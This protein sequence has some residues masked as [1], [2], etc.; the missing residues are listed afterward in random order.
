MF[1]LALLLLLVVAAVV[2]AMVLGGTANTIRL[3]FDPIDLVWQTTPLVVFVVGVA[4]TFVLLLALA[5]FRSASRRRLDQR[6]ELKRLR[7][8]E[9]DKDQT[10]AYGN[11]GRGDAGHTTAAGGSGPTSGTKPGGGKSG[12]QSSSSDT[13][14]ADPDRQ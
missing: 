6:R 13:M 8:A 7:Q 12:N 10:A 14:Y 9:K 4:T 1:V 5:L 2:A 11:A 3:D